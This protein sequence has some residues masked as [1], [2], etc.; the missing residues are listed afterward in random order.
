MDD[1][2]IKEMLK[3]IQNLDQIPSD[4]I[5]KAKKLSNTRAG[6]EMIKEM[7]DKG[8]NKEMIEKILTKKSETVTVLVIRPNGIVKPR[9]IT[10][11]E[12]CPSILHAILPTKIVKDQYC[13]WYDANIKTINK[14]AS[15]WLGVNVGGMIVIMGEDLNKINFK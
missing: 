9:E 14:K 10:L 8:I 7:H 2:T 6:R 15:K 5:A 11:N 12:E 3:N 13:I 4:M 1:E